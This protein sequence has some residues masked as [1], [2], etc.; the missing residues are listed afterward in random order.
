MTCCVVAY[1]AVAGSVRL[2]LGGGVTGFLVAGVLGTVVFAW[3]VH[4]QRGALEL[5]ALRGALRRRG[6]TR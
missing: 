2:V 4:R 6:R 1:G 3:L 5:M